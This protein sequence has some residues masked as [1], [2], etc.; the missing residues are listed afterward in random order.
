MS[1]EQDDDPAGAVD[2]CAAEWVVRHDG[3]A[4]TAD[5]RRAF[6]AWIA[7]PA[8]R[9]AYE[10]QAGIWRRY[11]QAGEQLSAAR[12]IPVWRRW[13]G[14]RVR[15]RRL[16]RKAFAAALAASMALLLVGQTGN[17]AAW[18]RADYATGVGE[19]RTVTLADGSR[20]EM[21]GRS[22]IAFEQT[23]Q[24]RSLRLL[25]GSALFTVAPDPTRPFTVRTMSG[26]VT[27]LGTAFA[28]RARGDTAELIVTEHS[29]RVRTGHGAQVT[30][31]EGEQVRFAADKVS[32]PAHIDTAAATAWTRGKLVVFDR[33]LGDVVA[34]IGRQRRGYWMV[35][36]DAA[37]IRVNGVYDLD[38]PLDAL[39]A[40][41]STL[42]LRSLRVSDRFIILSR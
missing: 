4:L 10:Y 41:E 15:D 23:D 35:Q 12:R 16:P 24:Q 3:E 39:D 21:D 26:D 6:A 34:E 18:L 30:V 9:A 8:H 27:A 33:P 28:I 7:D 14:S 1:I 38:H 42:K 37:T 11:R 29:V 13:K 17:W 20:V 19:R 31:N 32:K 5:E 22:A 36:G 25:E 40:L 2:M